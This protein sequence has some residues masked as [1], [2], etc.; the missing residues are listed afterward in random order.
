M[1]LKA[2]IV[3]LEQYQ[4]SRDRRFAG[5]VIVRKGESVKDAIAR[6]NLPKGIGFVILPEKLGNPG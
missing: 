1:K 6:T 2:R 5:V 4:R 3:K